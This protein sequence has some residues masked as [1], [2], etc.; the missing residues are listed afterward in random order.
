MAVIRLL[1]DS[2]NHLRVVQ[3]SGGS[4]ELADI[5]EAVSD[6]HMLSEVVLDGQVRPILCAVLSGKGVPAADWQTIY[7]L[8]SQPQSAE[9]SQVLAAIDGQLYRV[10]YLG[11]G[12]NEYIYRFRT[13]KERNRAVYID[14]QSETLYQSALCHAIKVARRTKEKSSGEPAVID[15]GAVSYVIPSHF[16][17]CLGV[18]NAI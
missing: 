8:R 11:M 14:G 7:N 17:F 10:P 6:W 1:F 4:Y 18:Q 9:L 16:G 15:F 5:A 13:A 12:E 2:S 3:N